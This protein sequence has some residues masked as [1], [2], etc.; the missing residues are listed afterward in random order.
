MQ[1]G[2]CTVAQILQTHRHKECAIRSIRTSKS[3][4]EQCAQHIDPVFGHKP[5]G[6]FPSCLHDGYEK[7]VE[8]KEKAEFET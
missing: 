5:E 2:V 1:V 4:P 6:S 3:P 8:K 7:L